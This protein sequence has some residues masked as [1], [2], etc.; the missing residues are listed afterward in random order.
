MVNKKKANLEII[1]FDDFFKGAEETKESRELN[2]AAY[3]A[4]LTDEEIA[5]INYKHNLDWSILAGQIVGGEY[6]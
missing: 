4:I 3:R 5:E 2:E 1:G 6:K